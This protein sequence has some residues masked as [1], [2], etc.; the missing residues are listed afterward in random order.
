[1][2]VPFLIPLPLLIAVPLILL[3]A[4]VGAPALPRLVA[5]R[6]QAA[7][8]AAV[9][10]NMVRLEL[11]VGRGRS[12]GPEAAIAA[13]RG[14]HPGRRTGVDRPWPRGWPPVE[15]RVVWRDGEL[16]WQLEAA[17]GELDRAEATLASLYP[18]LE[19]AEVDRSDRPAVYSAVGRL[20]RSSGLALGEPGSDGANVLTRLATILRSQSDDAEVRLRLLA[21]PMDPAA[22]Q[23][24][25]YPEDAPSSFGQ[26]LRGA[27]VDVILNRESGGNARTAPALSAPE[28]EARTRKRKGIAGFEVGLLLEVAGVDP[29][30]AKAILWSAINATSSL[31]TGTQAITWDL[32]AGSVGR[33]PRVALADFELA[34]LWYLPDPYFDEARLPRQ[35]ALAAPPPPRRLIMPPG[36]VIGES[37]GRPLEVPLSAIARHMAVVGATGSGKSTLIAELALG[38][39]DHDAG[40]TVIDPHGDLATDILE[41]VPAR[42]ANRVHVLRLA[43]RANPRAFN[44]LERT[45]PD[46]GQLVA[47]EFVG[48][49]HDL[50]PD[51]TGPKMQHYL[52]HALLTLLAAPEPQ[53]ILELIRVL[54]DDAFRAPYTAKLDDPLLASF[55][56]TEWPSPGGRENDNSIKAVLNKLGAFVSYDSIRDVVG[57]GESTIRPRQIMDRGDLLVVDCSQVGG[58]NARLFGAMCISRFYVDATGRQGTPKHQRRQHF[59]IVDEV[60]TFDTEALRRIIDEGRKFGLALVA[61]SQSLRGMGERLRDSVLTNAGVI[62]LISPG[63]DDVAAVRRMF[64]SM[65]PDAFLGLPQ[66]EMLVRTPGPDGRPTVYG[67]RVRRPPAGDPVAAAAILA[68][69]DARDGRD[70]EGV[71]YEVRLRSG[72]GRSS[73]VS[74]RSNGNGHAH[75]VDG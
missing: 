30:K 75:L 74:P 73:V 12:T 44:F 61:A 5:R 57:Q 27:I 35:R 68:H 56:A 51:F 15:L 18:G 71:H 54:T 37:R 34:S 63:P 19:T 52:R 50:W 36:V 32:R 69:S 22:W 25:L 47:S 53:T 13:I 70:P 28:L 45:T 17:S 11:T 43:D 46:Q 26:I 66:H 60:S 1:M 16:H 58:D 39:L 23:R 59:L 4:T 31:D 41:R 14:L 29:A 33:P 55:W 48:L 2:A 38:V 9:A 7:Y 24:S 62:A 67:G 8:D 21:R 72:G 42:H 3:I 10:P 64:D 20:R 65:P 6:R 49:I 40:A